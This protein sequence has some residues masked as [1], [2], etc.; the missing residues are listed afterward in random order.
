MAETRQSQVK[1]EKI[2]NPK[3]QISNKSKKYK[4]QIQKFNF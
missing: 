1:R 2:K 4:L 3:L